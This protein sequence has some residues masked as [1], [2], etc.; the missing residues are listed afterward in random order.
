[1]AYNAFI[2][3][4]EENSART[5]TLHGGFCKLSDKDFKVNLLACACSFFPE[6]VCL[7]TNATIQLNESKE[8][9]D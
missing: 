3:I 7:L 1:M 2:I 5:T 8:L 4:F 9:F 6:F